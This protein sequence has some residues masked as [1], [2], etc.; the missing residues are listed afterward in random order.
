MSDKHLAS[1]KSFFGLALLAL[2][3]LIGWHLG[4]ALCADLKK[5]FDQEWNT[6]WMLLFMHSERLH[7]DQENRILGTLTPGAEAFWIIFW[8]AVS[9]E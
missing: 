6:F 3:I 7:G 8:F 4:K 9:I 5:V 2:S 1:E